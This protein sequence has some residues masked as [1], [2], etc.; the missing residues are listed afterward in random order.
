VTQRSAASDRLIGALIGLARA[1][2]G[3]EHLISA[4]VADVAAAALC[5]E[6]EFDTLLQRIETVKREI[7]PD[8]YLCASPCGR[9]NAYDLNRWEQEPEEIQTLKAQLL[10]TLRDL[11]RQGC[12]DRMLFRMLIALGIDGYAA[13]DLEV[14]LTQLRTLS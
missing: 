4:A 11:A 9:N 3:N 5:A 10:D 7:V 12:R 2:E 14:F 8:C 13:A 1:T 6:T